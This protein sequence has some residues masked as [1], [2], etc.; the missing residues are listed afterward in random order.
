MAPAANH[1]TTSFGEEIVARA[2]DW[3]GT[4]YRHQAT[5]KGGGT[6]CLGL[7]RGVWREIY[8]REPEIVP[9]YTA[10][11][12]E[13]SGDELLLEAAERH[14]AAVDRAAA[15]PGDLLLFRMRDAGP[16]KHVGILAGSS[17]GYETMVHAY[18][19]YGVL[20]SPLGPPMKR[21]LVGIFRFPDRSN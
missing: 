18:S 20:E 13:S 16:A 8:G 7:L 4:P 14:L 5:C 2:R 15:K 17:A 19:R 3:I 10:D 9:A 21:R 11:W 1:N 6:D 12:G